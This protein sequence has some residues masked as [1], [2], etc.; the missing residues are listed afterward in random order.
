[1]NARGA[2]LFVAGA[3]GIALVAQSGC[4]VATQ[5]T[6]DITYAGPCPS[7]LNVGVIASGDTTQAQERI[8][9]KSFTTVTT[10]CTA[11]ANGRSHVG[12]LVVTPGEGSTR[13]AI[14]VV[15]GIAKPAESCNAIEGFFGCIVARRSF[16]FVSHAAPHFPILL[17]P[18]CQNVPCDAVTTCKKGTCVASATECNEDT[19]G[20]EEAVDAGPPTDGPAGD[21]IVDSGPASDAPSD[22]PIDGPPDV[23]IV[24][25]GACVDHSSE[26]N[27]PKKCPPYPP[28]DAPCPGTTC[29]AY[30][31]SETFLCGGT[32]G[33]FTYNCAASRYCPQ[34]T[35]CQW[36]Q[37]A[38]NKYTQ[39]QPLNGALRRAC[40][41]DCDCPGGFKCARID[42]PPKQPGP[43]FLRVCRNDL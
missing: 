13:G 19:C 26:F 33:Q 15:A 14:V 41:D 24:D 16:A 22:G 21:A 43:P 39:C 1:M 32:G 10:T 5:V 40:E 3:I 18:I 34:L 9:S 37:I 2:S 8:A 6:L 23:S 36:D 7:A 17:D 28:G 35:F 25:S 20:G 12:T 4:R 31:P 11:G 42:A 29:E 27:R 38:N 30:F